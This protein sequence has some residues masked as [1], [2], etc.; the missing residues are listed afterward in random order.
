KTRRMTAQKVE[1]QLFERVG[2][3][4]DVGKR[5]EAGVDTVRWFGAACR[6][7]DHGSGRIHP[8]ARLVGE[9]DRLAAMGNRD[10]LVEGQGGAVEKNHESLQS[11]VVSRQSLVISLQSHHQS[12]RRG[13]A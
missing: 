10:D 7:V 3:N 4:R 11:P 8:G 2:R 13:I 6:A 12:K 9:R 1:L 5:S